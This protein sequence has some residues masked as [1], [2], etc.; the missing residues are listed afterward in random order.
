M[1]DSKIVLILYEITKP[2]RALLQLTWY[3]KDCWSF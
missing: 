1:G 3:L 2:D